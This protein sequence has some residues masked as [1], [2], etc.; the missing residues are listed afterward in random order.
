VEAVTKGLEDMEAA[1]IRLY[2][3]LLFSQPMERKTKIEQRKRLTKLL[4]RARE[5]VEPFLELLSCLCKVAL[6]YGNQTQ[7]V[8]GSGYGASIAQVSPQFQASS[9]LRLG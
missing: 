5:K 1:V 7:I 3:R 4:T 9:Q 6:D 2:S 8:E